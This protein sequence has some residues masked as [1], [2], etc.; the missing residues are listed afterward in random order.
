M[1]LC[2]FA[3]N[4]LLT[5]IAPAAAL[6]PADAVALHAS[7]DPSLGAL[8]AGRVEAPAALGECE[9]SELAAAQN[10]SLPLS[11]LRGGFEPTN[12]EWKWL[13]IGAGVVLVLV[14]V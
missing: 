4:L 9:R 7:F 14:L 13:A 8:R 6:S 1:L 3:A 11:A 10:Q 12:N 2:P 5:C